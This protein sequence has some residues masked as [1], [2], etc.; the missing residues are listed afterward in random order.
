MPLKDLTAR[1]AYAKLQYE[2]NRGKYILASQLQK[3]RL[4][5]EKVLVPRAAPVKKPC[6]SCGRARESVL[7][8]VRGN[9][10]KA[11]VSAYQQAYREANTERIAE[12]KRQWKLANKDHVVAR[13]RLYAEKHPERR[14]QARKKWTAANPGKDTASKARNHQSR[15]K[16]TPPWLSVDDV[17]LIEQAY[18]LAAVRTKMFGFS[19][20]VDHIIPLNGRSVSG[21][22]V[23]TNLQVIPWQENLRKG[24]RVQH[25]E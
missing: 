16:R 21:L 20:H 3:V 24:N 12:G 10:C 18:E 9:T 22:H 13:D 11:C 25:G 7:F 8:P 6:A 17:W 1:K 2:R 15:Q 19:W 14:T 23:P 4:K 5:A